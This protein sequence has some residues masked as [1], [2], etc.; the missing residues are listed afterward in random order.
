MSCSIIG[1]T[2]GENIKVILEQMDS[3]TKPSNGSALQNPELSRVQLLTMLR[4]AAARAAESG[5]HRRKQHWAAFMA[6]YK[7]Q[8]PANT[9]R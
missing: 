8:E 3:R 7:T 6:G 9:N 2:I 5:E 1:D 4:R